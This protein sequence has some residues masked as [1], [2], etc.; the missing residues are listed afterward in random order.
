M[1]GKQASLPEHLARGGRIQHPGQ[2][3][4]PFDPME[5]AMKE[6]G[7]RTLANT[8]H[9]HKDWTLVQEYPALREAAGHVARLALAG[10]HRTM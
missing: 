3:G 6:L 9:L 8:E 2:P 5:K 4:D 1:D 7:G 10:R